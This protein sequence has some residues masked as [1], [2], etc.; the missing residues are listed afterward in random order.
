MLGTGEQLRKVAITVEELLDH[1]AKH[2]REWGE[3]F[4]QLSGY[5]H[6][7]SVCPLPWKNGDVVSPCSS[8]LVAVKQQKRENSDSSTSRILGPPPRK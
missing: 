6:H 1:S 7:S 3:S 4:V 5:S 2:L 8:I